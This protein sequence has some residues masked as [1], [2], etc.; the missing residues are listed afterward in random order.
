MLNSI[1]HSPT[2]ASCE[3]R[4]VSAI[5]AKAALIHHFPGLYYEHDDLYWSAAVVMFRLAHSTLVMHNVCRKEYVHYA[6]SVIFCMQR[7]P[8]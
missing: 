8:Q 1:H 5:R 7:I 2:D 3:I 4:Y 6:D